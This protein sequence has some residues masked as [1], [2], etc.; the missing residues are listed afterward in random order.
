[1]GCSQIRRTSIQKS[2]LWSPWR[3]AKTARVNVGVVR[4]F[5]TVSQLKSSFQ[6]SINLLANIQKN[7][8]PLNL[9]LQCQP[10][11]LDIVRPVITSCPQLQWHLC[12]LLQCRDTRK[13]DNSS[14]SRFQSI[15]LL[16]T[17]HFQETHCI[18]KT[19]Q[20]SSVPGLTLCLSQ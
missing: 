19:M 20:S 12:L 6:T 2:H 15:L 17:F 14:T 7:K 3:S 5:L 1:M 11:I 8:F 9:W 13:K 18:F 4:R 10:M 16:S